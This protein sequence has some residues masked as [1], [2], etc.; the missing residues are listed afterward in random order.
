MEGTEPIKSSEARTGL[1]KLVRQVLE[2]RQD[3]L[4]EQNGEVVAKLTV[5][6]PASYVAL[7]RLKV[8]EAREGWSKLLESVIRG[9]KWFFVLKLDPETKVYLVRHDAYKNE[10]SERYAAEARKVRH[11]QDVSK[12]ADALRDV[13]SAMAELRES[14]VGRIDGVE[15]KIACLFALVNRG[16]DLLATPESGIVP[17]RRADDL[18]HF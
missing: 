5:T 4:I 6:Q 10:F 18:D 13:E 15:Q 12:A 7:V 16:G 2:T 1:A 3:V 9:A 11:K 17:L 14:M 8:P